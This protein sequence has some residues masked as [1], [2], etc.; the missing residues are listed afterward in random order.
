M[1]KSFSKY[2]LSMWVSSS[3]DIFFWIVL[4]RSRLE[5]NPTPPSGIFVSDPACVSLSLP[6]RCSDKNHA[7]AL[8]CNV[9]FFFL[10]TSQLSPSHA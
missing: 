5:K 7:V 6:R 9:R 3:R 4:I 1:G 8:L 2:L 10:A